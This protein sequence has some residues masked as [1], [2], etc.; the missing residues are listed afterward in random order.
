M[1]HGQPR[2]EDT[3]GCVVS[4]ERWAVGMEIVSFDECWVK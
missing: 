3:R 1:S 2:G 4:G